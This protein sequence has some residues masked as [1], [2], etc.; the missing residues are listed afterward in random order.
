[1]R[2]TNAALAILALLFLLTMFKPLEAAR[3]LDEGEEELMKRGSLLLQSL[4]K[5]PVPPSGSGPGTHIPATNTL[6]HKGFA[7]QAMPPPVH[8]QHTVQFGVA[9]N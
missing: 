4:Q 2:P 8:P 5:G 9:T 3:I 7:G 6:G 1:M